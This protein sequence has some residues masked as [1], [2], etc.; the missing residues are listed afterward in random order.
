MPERFVLGSVLEDLLE[1]YLSELS[2]HLL[3]VVETSLIQL[4]D[5]F[6]LFHGCLLSW[7]FKVL[8]RYIGYDPMTSV[9]KTEMLPLH[10]YRIVWSDRSGL[11]RRH[12]RWQRSAL[13]LS[14]DRK[15]G[16]AGW[17]CTS[18]LLVLSQVSFYFSTAQC[19]YILI[20]SKSKMAIPGRLE[21]PTCCLEGSCSVQLSYGTMRSCICD[22]NALNMYSSNCAA[23]THTE[24]LTQ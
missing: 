19:N 2:N 24:E 13:P 9:W 7:V 5:Q 6:A 4:V 22:L 18:D 8:E 1:L 14:Y 16:C 15:F 20:F 12:L 3:V 21:R 23:S 11:N 10:Q 17:N